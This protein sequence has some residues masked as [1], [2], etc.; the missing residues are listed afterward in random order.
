MNASRRIALIDGIRGVAIVL[1]DGARRALLH[2]TAEFATLSEA[3][4]WRP[5]IDR[6]PADTGR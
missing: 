3:L 5:S 6:G 2:A 1:V 4:A